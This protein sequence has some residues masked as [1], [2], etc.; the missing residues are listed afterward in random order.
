M[1]DFIRLNGTAVRTTGFYRR[2]IPHPDGPPLAEIELV[3]IIRGTMAN[4]SLKQLLSIEPIRVDIPKGETVESFSASIEH[5]MVGS[6]GTGEAAAYRFDLT[7]R[8]TP[9][10]A[11]LREAERA[12]QEEV[13]VPERLLRAT[14]AVQE[15]EP[16]L[17]IS[18][19]KVSGDSAT[20]APAIKQM[21]APVGVKREVPEEPLTATERAGIEAILVNLRMD[22][23]IDELEAAGRVRRTDVDK[24]FMRLVRNRFVS[25]ATPVVGERVAK[26]AERDLLG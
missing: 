15:A 12:Q 22:A 2:T 19:V 4:R 17:E 8:E 16:D 5:V 14:H 9:E 26:R 21:T 25:E 20:W 3:I 11:K 6:S 1:S 13:S 23:L 18:H 7:L 24:T 10:S